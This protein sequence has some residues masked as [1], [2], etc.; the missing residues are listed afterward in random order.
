MSNFWNVVLYGLSWSSLFAPMTIAKC[1]PVPCA[2]CLSDFHGE[3]TSPPCYTH[4]LFS[5]YTT[6]LSRSQDRKVSIAAGYRLYDW[7]VGVQVLVGSR[8]SSSPCRSDWLRPTQPPI[9]WVLEALSPGVKRTEREV[10]HS[11]P[12]STE[13]KKTWIHTSTPPYIYMV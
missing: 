6:F 12:T 9:Q 1:K 2:R 13:V 4:F 5:K 7:G 10:D 11:P 3:Y 8:T